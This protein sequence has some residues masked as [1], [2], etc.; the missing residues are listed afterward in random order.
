MNITQEFAADIRCMW[1]DTASD[2]ISVC[3]AEYDRQSR[4]L[5]RGGEIT[6]RTARNLALARIRAYLS[7]TDTPDQ[8]LGLLSTI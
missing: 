3:L 4:K 6:L 5:A 7:Q 8:F 2:V 1:E